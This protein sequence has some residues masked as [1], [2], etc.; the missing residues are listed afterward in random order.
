MYRLAIVGI[1]GVRWNSVGIRWKLVRWNFVGIRW[2]SFSVVFCLQMLWFHQIIWFLNAFLGFHEV[3]CS[4]PLSLS[5]YLCL[6]VTI[7]ST[8][9]I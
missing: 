3:L 2:N 7:F 8:E 1:F 4:C 9:G 6:V 5:T